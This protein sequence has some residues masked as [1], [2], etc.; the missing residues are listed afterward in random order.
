VNVNY[1]YS[2]LVVCIHYWRRGHPR[3]HTVPSVDSES[4]VSTTVSAVDCQTAR[5]PGFHTLP[6]VRLSPHMQGQAPAP[7]KAPALHGSTTQ[8][9][10]AVDS[11]GSGDAQ[12]T[13]ALQQRPLMLQMGPSLQLLMPLILVVVLASLSILLMKVESLVLDMALVL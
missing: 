12:A 2:K 8:S 11:L 3:T 4:D 13:D 7:A 5:K 10:P 1:D 6:E 9:D